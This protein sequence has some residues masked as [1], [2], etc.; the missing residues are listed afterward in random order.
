MSGGLMNGRFSAETERFINLIPSNYKT[1]STYSRKNRWKPLNHLRVSDSKDLV[2][3]AAPVVT[4]GNS[5]CVSSSR[6]FFF[7]TTSRETERG[8]WRK[9]AQEEEPTHQKQRTEANRSNKSVFG[10]A[11]PGSAAAH[12]SQP[13]FILTLRWANSKICA[14]VRGQQMFLQGTVTP[15]PQTGSCSHRLV[16]LYPCGMTWTHTSTNT[17]INTHINTSL[18]W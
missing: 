6:F 10:P 9:P 11:P 15:D 8:P 12:Q 18:L 14:C 5:R 16:T 2:N 3:L 13:S 4:A 7:N 17:H 1:N